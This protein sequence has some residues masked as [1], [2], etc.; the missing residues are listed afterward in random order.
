MGVGHNQVTVGAFAR[1]HHGGLSEQL[2]DEGRTHAR[3][4]PDEGIDIVEAQIE[5]LTVELE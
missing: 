2:F 1:R 4:A 3:G 5:P